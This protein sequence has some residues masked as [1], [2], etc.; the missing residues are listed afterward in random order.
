MYDAPSEDD[1]E[2]ASIAD[3]SFDDVPLQ[4]TSLPSISEQLD[5]LLSPR[6]DAPAKFDFDPIITRRNSTS[7]RITSVPAQ[8]SQELEQAILNLPCDVQSVKSSFSSANMPPSPA[9][10]AASNLLD[11]KHLLRACS[12]SRADGSD[13][14][15]PILIDTGCSTACSGYASDFHGQLIEGQFGTIKTADGIAQIEGFGIL[16]WATVDVEGQ[17]V[18]IKVPGYHVPSVQMRLLSPQDYTRYHGI[19]IEDDGNTYFGNDDRMS[20]FVLHS[21]SLPLAKVTAPIDLQSRLPFFFAES[22]QSL[23]PSASP[24]QPDPCPC[25]ATVA[26]A[27]SLH[28]PR[29]GNLSRPRQ[30]LKLDHDRLGHIGFSKLQAMYKCEKT[31]I[32]FDGSTSTH[33][34]CLIAA[35]KDMLSCSPPKCAT[36][37][38]ANAKRRSKGSTIS[39]A[40]PEKTDVLRSDDLA[41]GDTVSSDQYESSVRGQLPSSRGRAFSSGRRAVGGT[42]FF[43]HASGKISVH[44]QRSLSAADTIQAKRDFERAALECGV[45]IKKYHTD[46]GIYDSAAF[47]DE[48]EEGDFQAHTKS[49]VGAH[50]QNGVAE[51]AIGTVHAMARAMLLHIRIHWPDEFDPALWTYALDYAVYIYNHLPF[52]VKSGLCPNEV[53][54]GV[55]VGCKPL[56]RLRVFGCPAYVLDPRLQDG[57]RIPKWSPRSR[58]GQ[59]L[60]FSPSHSST[61]VLVRNLRTGYVSPQFHVV[62]DE[63]FETVASEMMIDLEEHWIDLFRDSRDVFLD[64][65]DP[66]VDRLPEFDDDYLDPSDNQRPITVP[67]DVNNSA[68]PSPPPAQAGAPPPPVP[69]IAPSPAAVVPPSRDSSVTDPLSSVAPNSGVQPDS[70]QQHQ[71]QQPSQPDSHQQGGI[72][73][74]LHPILPVLVRL[75]VRPI[76]PASAAFSASASRILLAAG[77]EAVL[78]CRRIVASFPVISPTSNTSPIRMISPSPLSIGKLSPTI[79]FTRRSMICSP[80][81]TIQ[82]RASSSM[83]TPSIPLLSLPR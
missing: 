35:D 33:D 9:C 70:N 59:F 22:L 31:L 76:K 66:S 3:E 25:R 36:C 5:A 1:A 14:V 44:H 7:I 11:D 68:N 45:T 57:R 38:A 49:G 29:N 51:R 48:L 69:P 34:P 2:S 23:Q 26:P 46:N 6:D 82:P 20:M 4:P 16:H 43:D 32:H 64:W 54:S 28:D 67:V 79:R 77:P 73:P 58:S 50:H 61:I 83:P 10:F 30:L 71:H 17:P 24:A 55:V 15:F 12:A 74:R 37:F 40:N 52:D 80:D 53:F 19:K 21:P 65:Y 75:V 47:E 81:S 41:P 27:I 8:M 39:R 62:F 60:G 13:V 72:P 78:L 56:R 18:L 63:R 42:L